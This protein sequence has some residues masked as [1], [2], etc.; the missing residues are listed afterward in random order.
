MESVQSMVRPGRCEDLFYVDGESAAKQCFPTTVNTKFSQGMNPGVAGGTSTFTIPP[1]SG[2]QDI[3]VEVN[4]GVPAA[5]AGAVAIPNGWVY[6]L[7]KTVS[8]RYGGSSMFSLTGD[9]VL[10][11]A[12]K[13]QQS[14]QAAS[15]LLNAGGNSIARD[16]GVPAANFFG[17]AVLV[18]PHSS[19]SGVGKPH[20]FPLSDLT[21]QVVIQIEWNSIGTVLSCAV[22]ADA[23]LAW[24]YAS[25][26][27]VVQQVA[28]NNSADAL[29]R[30]V[31]MSKNCYAYPV[32]FIQQKV[33]IPLGPGAGPAA[34][35][36]LALTGFRSGEVKAIHCW[37]TNTADVSPTFGA[38]SPFLWYPPQAVTLSYA[39]D[40][41][42]K[43]ENS[44]STLW[45]LINGRKA[46]TFDQV[47]TTGAG[48]AA[49]TA[50]GT[51][52]ELPFA[53]THVGDDEKTLLVHGRPI[54]NG[55]CNISI[56][57]PYYPHAGWQPATDPNWVLN[58]SYI[59]GATIM[60]AQGSS[61]FLF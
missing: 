1:G 21:Q 40:V 30:R 48:V 56:A 57:P 54:T 7:M 24:S 5:L 10:Q 29:S 3:V 47:G 55:V 42:A 37:L 36:Q 59:Y 2:I 43:Y 15:D 8:Y 12:L 13:A 17:N 61:D 50:L 27:C 49:A 14:K 9:Q 18:L 51:W 26:N 4:L 35:A 33:S 39:G 23:Q 25:V 58:V 22:P 16:P 32:E 20:P 45:A 52:I 28:L 46:P 31:D 41:Y 53:Q 6:A 44:S 60:V 19:P 11:A 38:K 34:P